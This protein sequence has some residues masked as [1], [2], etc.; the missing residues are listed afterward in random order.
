MFYT[1]CVLSVLIFLPLASLS[2]SAKNRIPQISYGSTSAILSDKAKY[3]YFFRTCP[4]DVHQ[5]AVLAALFRKYLF[6]EVGTVATND[7]YGKELADM[8]EKEVTGMAD[9]PVSVVS[10]Q[11][12]DVN[13]RAASVRPKIQKV[14]GF[15]FVIRNPSL[16][17]LKLI[18]LVLFWFTHTHLVCL[19]LKKLSFRGL[20][21]F[22]GNA[23]V[24]KKWLKISRDSS[25]NWGDRVDFLRPSMVQLLSFLPNKK[26]LRLLL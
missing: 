10:R 8:F 9:V 2:G 20:V 5:A 23:C 14:T 4:S 21:Q 18:I 24:A 12:F 6:P 17:S 19:Y 3:K 22:Q 11:R 25:I 13:A 26:L 15:K 1:W 7:I 16:F